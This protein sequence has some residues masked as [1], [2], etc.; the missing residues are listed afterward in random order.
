MF[1]INPGCSKYGL[2]VI[3]GPLNNLVRSMT[4]IQEWYNC[5]LPEKIIDA[6]GDYF[7][8]FFSLTKMYVR[9]NRFVYNNL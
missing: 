9:Y 6:N 3:C 4:T 2:Q 8:F 5:G 1:S 7:S